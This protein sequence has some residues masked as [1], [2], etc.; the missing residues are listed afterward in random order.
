MMA[1][2]M[3]ADESRRP[4]KNRAD[5]YPSLREKWWRALLWRA[6]PGT[7]ALLGCAAGVFGA[8][9]GLEWYIDTNPDSGGYYGEILEALAKLALWCA[10]CGIV[11][12]II[13]WW[14]GTVIA[15][16]LRNR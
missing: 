11:G 13:G 4:D 5:R 3:Y 9:K 1:S 12:S 15:R 16:R 2:I 10:S 8:F 6:L 7:G 14:I